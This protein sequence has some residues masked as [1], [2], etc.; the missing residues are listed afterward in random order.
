MSPPRRAA[1]SYWPPKSPTAALF[2]YP[3]LVLA[4]CLTTAAA[5]VVVWINN[6]LTCSAAVVA[7]CGA[8]FSR[9]ARHAVAGGACVD[10][11]AVWGVISRLQSSSLPAACELIDAAVLSESD[12]KGGKLSKV[13]FTVAMAEARWLLT[14]NGGG[15]RN[16]APP[17]LRLTP[18][19]HV[20]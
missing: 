18:R 3:R 16:L 13:G 9:A 4:L 5:L 10:S 6:G 14:S 20:R 17:V 8:A 11:R 12:P 19:V 15:L 2:K 7:R 1:A